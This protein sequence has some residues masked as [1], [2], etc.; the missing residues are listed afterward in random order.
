MQ[1][2]DPL[3]AARE[4]GENYKLRL[5]ETAGGWV[6]IGDVATA[7]RTGA[8]HVQEM[9]ADGRL[10]S[11]EDSVPACLI[12]DGRV[13]PGLA[14]VLAVMNVDGFWSRLSFMLAPDEELG[15]R[16]PLEALNTGNLDSVLRV[17]A[18][19]GRQ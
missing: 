8:S 1:N 11:L 3:R 19:F 2:P 5:I 6:S 7:L 10:L 15:G 4:R 9:I 16:T 14:E 13:A 18:H 17:A 12:A